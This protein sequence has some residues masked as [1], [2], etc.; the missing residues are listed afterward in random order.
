MNNNQKPDS[1]NVST[2]RSRNEK[3][4]KQ[5]E[6]E[7]Q[8]KAGFLTDSMQKSM[9]IGT[10]DNPQRVSYVPTFRVSTGHKMRRF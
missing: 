4:K 3:S 6:E 8:Q 2:L 1:T 5:L 9:F 10:Q 7:R